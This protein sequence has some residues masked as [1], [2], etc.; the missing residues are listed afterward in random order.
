VEE[1]PPKRKETYRSPWHCRA[2]RCLCGQCQAGKGGGRG[3]QC[4]LFV[5]ILTLDLSEGSRIYTSGDMISDLPPSCTVNF[6][7]SLQSLWTSGHPQLP[8]SAD[9]LDGW[10]LTALPS[11]W[12]CSLPA[13]LSDPVALRLRVCPD[14]LF[15]SGAL[16][17]HCVAHLHSTAT[18]WPA[19]RIRF[20][21][22][23]REDHVG[24]T[25]PTARAVGLLHE[26]CRVR[27]CRFK[28]SEIE[29]GTL[30]RI[31]SV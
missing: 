6:R 16:T 22:L 9:T 27:V 7:V 17:C 20:S 24:N 3:W 13:L 25:W 23:R 26:G 5:L 10:R 15:P 14:S 21:S 30:L 11:L 2:E 29:T 12:S 18:A 8:A 31:C 1:Q 28:Q 4:R 19:Q